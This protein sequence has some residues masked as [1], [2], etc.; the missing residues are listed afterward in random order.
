[1]KHRGGYQLKQRQ[2]HDARGSQTYATKEPSSLR[3]SVSLFFRRS[4][5]SGRFGHLSGLLLLVEKAKLTFPRIA[6]SI[7]VWVQG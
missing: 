5:R 4:I 6:D 1:V 7:G 3:L 2:W